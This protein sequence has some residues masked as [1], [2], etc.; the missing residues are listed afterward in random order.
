M[1]I[2]KVLSFGN[3]IHRL[4]IGGRRWYNEADNSTERNH[5]MEQEL[6]GIADRLR[7]TFQHAPEDAGRSILGQ[8]DPSGAFPDIDYASTAR[9]GWPPAAH[10]ARLSLLAQGYAA[11]ADAGD[12]VAAELADGVVR[13]LRFW[14]GKDCRSLNWWHNDLGV[15][16]NLRLIPL[17]LR[18]R[19]PDDCRAGV[20]ARLQSEIDP[21]WTGT[22]K[23]WFA[24]NVIFRGLL[25]GD[26]AL[27]L[28]GVRAMEETVRTATESAAEEGVLPDG[29]FA[30]H[31]VQLYSNGYGKSF[32]CN[33]ATWIAV[34]EGTFA[35]F[36]D[37]SVKVLTDLVLGGHARMCRYEAIDFNTQGREVV[38]EYRGRADM[39]AYIPALEILMRVN[40]ADRRDR[41]GQLIA[42]IRRERNDPGQTGCHMFWCTDFM[43]QT[44]P[45][46]YASTRMASDR[47]LG[48]DVC[49]GR[50]VNG[51]DLLAGF[52]AYCLTSYMVDGYEYDR[53]YPVWDWGMLPGVSCPHEELYIEAGAIHTSP[54]AGGVSHGDRGVCGMNFEK[55]YT[56]DETVT[57]GGKKAVFY[58]GDAVVHLGCGLHAGCKKEMRTCL[59]QPLLRGPVLADGREVPDCPE[60]MPL[61]ARK[62][63]HAGIGY[64]LPEGQ[65][66]LWVRLGERCGSWRRI[67]AAGLVPDEPVRHPVAAF[68]ISHG[69]SPAGASYRFAVL[70]GT[71]AQAL[72]RFCF[73]ERFAVGNT[74]A[75]QWVY[76]KRDRV[77]A[78]VFHTPGTA[79]DRDHTVT[80]DQ[81]C[82]LLWCPD[83]TVKVANPILKDQTVALTLR[84]GGQ[85]RLLHALMP[86]HPLQVG[87]GVYAG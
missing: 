31:G 86:G 82:F 27:L 76:D 74:D 11:A 65:G 28:R 1:Y 3:I 67:S 32:V 46:Y 57:F 4:A 26:A 47:V 15:P 41:L 9:G 5:P 13:G 17:Y 54:F 59:D 87:M 43:T 20:I 70:P 80:V 63:W 72:E 40:P 48:A 21:K 77:F 33:T 64:C 39:R 66:G 34:L 60:G 85:E 36:R 53:I 49:G 2:K 19:L 56:S 30:Q 10:P 29:S 52:G 18:D 79:G 68:W 12:P 71:D 7:R 73:E 24:E 81:P 42:F 16:Q 38:R 50:I 45:G 14:L 44:Q 22:N 61:A 58:M 37:E 55:Q 75:A 8:M 51:E 23:S 69:I 83:G 84:Q 62:L 6:Q 25:T 78:A 35:A